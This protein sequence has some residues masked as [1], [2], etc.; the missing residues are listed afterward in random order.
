MCKMNSCAFAMRPMATNRLID[1][2]WNKNALSEYPTL[3]KMAQS[4]LLL[5]PHNMIV[6]KGFS[7]MKTTE[8]VY[9]NRMNSDLYDACR[10]IRDF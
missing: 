5:T 4:L 10:L 6:E 3:Y 8:T 9:A 1:Q 2:L 7:K